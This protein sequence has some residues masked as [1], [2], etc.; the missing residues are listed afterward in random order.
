MADNKLVRKSSE[1]MASRRPHSSLFGPSL[2]GP[3]VPLGDFFG[4]NPFALMREFTREMD[5][6]FSGSLAGEGAAQGWAPAIEMKEVNGNLVVTAELPGIKTEDVKV[7][8]NDEMLT[9][10]GERRMEKKEEKEGVYRSERSYGRFYRAI[11]LPDGAKTEQIKAEMNNGVLEVKIP[12][13]EA[14]QKSRQIPVNA[15]ES[16]KEPEKKTAAA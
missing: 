10:E 1:E 15:A 12:L 8:V 9:L 7:E 11:P 3:R 5:R 16:M 6:A 14:K 2:F 4:M 13:A